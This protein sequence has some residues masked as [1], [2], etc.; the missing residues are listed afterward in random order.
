[1]PVVLARMAKNGVNWRQ[2]SRV[3]FVKSRTKFCEN[4]VASCCSVKQDRLAKISF[5][6]I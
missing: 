2:Q 6:K 5:I 1:M 3:R 4:S